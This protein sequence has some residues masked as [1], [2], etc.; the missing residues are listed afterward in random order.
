MYQQ[1]DENAASRKKT[2][3][4]LSEKERKY[5][6][7]LRARAN[8]QKRKAYVNTLEQRIDDLEDDNKRKY[9]I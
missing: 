2:R 4:K 1:V 9:I 6:D 8:R 7:M 5:N 3:K